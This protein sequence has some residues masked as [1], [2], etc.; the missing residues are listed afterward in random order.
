MDSALLTARS[1]DNRYII[2][3]ITKCYIHLKPW[4]A[5]VE[6][7]LHLGSAPQACFWAGKSAEMQMGQD[8]THQRAYC[9]NAPAMQT[10]SLE[11]LPL[12]LQ[13]DVSPLGQSEKSR[14]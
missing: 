2:N 1:Y 8:A 11:T 9:A 5:V 6:S 4:L 14:V 3:M 12:V 13:R 7:D 10:G